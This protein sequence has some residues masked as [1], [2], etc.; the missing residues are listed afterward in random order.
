MKVFCPKHKTEKLRVSCYVTNSEQRERLD[1][2]T[3]TTDWLFCEKC[4]K[5][6]KPKVKFS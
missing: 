5:P 6:Y 2:I 4:N 3:V 1:L